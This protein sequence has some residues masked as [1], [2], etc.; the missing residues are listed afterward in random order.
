M[1]GVLRVV[2]AEEV[3]TSAAVVLLQVVLHGLQPQPIE[4]HVA[5]W[6]GTAI[7]IGR[8]KLNELFHINVLAATLMLVRASCAHASLSNTATTLRGRSSILP[9]TFAANDRVNGS[10]AG[11]IFLCHG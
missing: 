3:L 9:C 1:G 4:A 2:M 5:L 10:S 6:V 7:A 11:G 8:W